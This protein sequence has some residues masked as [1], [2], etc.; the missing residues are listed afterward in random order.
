MAPHQWYL[1]NEDSSTSGEYLFIYEWEVDLVE[2]PE[3][4]EFPSAG[5]GGTHMSEQI[6]AIVPKNSVKTEH[7]LNMSI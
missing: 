4:K 6:G 1:I 2:I 7:N 5:R 3:Q